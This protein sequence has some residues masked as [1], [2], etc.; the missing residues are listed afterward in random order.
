MKVY[1]RLRSRGE[2][3][4]RRPKRRRRPR[5]RKGAPDNPCS[6]LGGR[7]DFLLRFASSL[8]AKWLQR[9]LVQQ[10][11]DSVTH[12]ST[13]RVGNEEVRMKQRIW[14]IPCLAC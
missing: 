11:L 9:W 2:G 7:C 3:F 4:E 12:V 1:Q 8:R 6:G 10:P 5:E 14:P 13:D